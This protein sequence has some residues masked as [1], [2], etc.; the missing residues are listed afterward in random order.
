MGLTVI[1]MLNAGLPTKVKTLDN[2]GLELIGLISYLVL[3]TLAWQYTL[4]PLQNHI[5]DGIHNITQTNFNF[6]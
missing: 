5:H 6:K 3:Y 2:I 1:I 4:F